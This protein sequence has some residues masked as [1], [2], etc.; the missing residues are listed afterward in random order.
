MHGDA[1]SHTLQA[2]PGVHQHRGLHA[3]CC[4]L[5][6]WLDNAEAFD[7]GFYAGPFGWVTGCGAEFVVAIRSGL[8]TPASASRPAAAAASLGALPDE[9]RDVHVYAGVGVVEGSDA[10]AEWQVRCVTPC[11]DGAVVL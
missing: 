4:R 5:C 6:R 7:R 10:D 8:V 11:H 2:R 9:V 1:G 3:A